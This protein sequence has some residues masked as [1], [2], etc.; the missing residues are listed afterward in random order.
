MYRSASANGDLEFEE[1]GLT[2][3]KGKGEMFTYFLIRNNTKSLWELIQ[4]EKGNVFGF[5]LTAITG[6]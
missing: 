5:K 3:V 6:R 2:Q 4:R 1:R